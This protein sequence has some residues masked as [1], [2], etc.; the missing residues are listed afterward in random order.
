ML[1]Y[2]K[3]FAENR[4]LKFDLHRLQIRVPE[5]ELYNRS[6]F[7]KCLDEEMARSRRTKLPVSL[8]SIRIDSFEEF[9]QK[10][11]QR[12]SLR[13]RKAIAGILS[14]TSRVT[15]IIADYENGDFIILLPHTSQKG[16]ALKAEKIRRI[17]EKTSFREA[18]LMPTRK[19]FISAGVSDYPAV[20]ADAEEILSSA[21]DA[22]Y[23][24]KRAGGNQVCLATKSEEFRPDFE[25]N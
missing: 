11:S 13:L 4:K 3:V 16:A 20:C 18:E 5:T 9:V 12:E 24:V 14:K 2:C 7:Q 6:F 25:A 22:L 8:I 23:F 1:E 10:T 17:I 21:D 15:D 19:V